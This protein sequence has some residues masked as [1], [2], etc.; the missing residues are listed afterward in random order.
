[1]G[2]GRELRRV[3]EFRPSPRR[4]PIALNGAIALALPAV[5]LTLAGQPTLGLVA[6]NGAFLALYLGDRPLLHRARRLPLIG[7][8][9]FASAALAVLVAPFPVLTTV[10]IAAIAIAAA[11]LTVGLRV[12]PP[13]SVFFAMVPGVMASMV[14]PAEDG[15]A[16]LDAGPLLGVL[17]LGLVVAYLVVVAPLA[18][19]AVL[20]RARSEPPP[21]PLRFEVGRES[22][23][24]LTRVVVALA[25][26][27]AVS[28]PLGSH[29]SYWVVVTV[30][31][32]LQS[33]IHR[34]LTTV[35]AANRI[36]GTVLGAGIFLV[37]ALIDLD[38]VVLILVLA[39]LQFCVELVI[40]RH[41]GLALVFITPLALL[42]A[43]RHPGVSAGA[44]VAERILD[45][46]LGAVLAVVVLVAE[47]VLE[48]RAARP[49]AG[50][51]APV[52]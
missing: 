9:L 44:V 3:V 30:V 7:A 21:A 16:G 14:A 23:I 40:V 25:L 29:R 31:A 4:W 11:V 17:A 37:V 19:P 36:L 26:A 24:V 10:L 32:V 13:G 50:R 20:R 34:R 6:S 48:R 33:G 43:V 46:A 41:Y 27:A 15:G 5:T 49:G 22:R 8:G 52:G 47:F 51:D 18:V 45:T 12:G 38:G 42:V 2:I 1:M 39:A 35:R 28:I